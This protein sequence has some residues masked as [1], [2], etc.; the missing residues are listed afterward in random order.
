MALIERLMGLEQ[1]KISVHLFQSLAAEWAQGS[2]TGTQANA[3]IAA[4]SGGVPLDAAAIA[5]ATALVATVPTG[6][7]SALKADRAL[8]LLDIDHVLLIAESRIPPYDTAAAVRTRLG[9]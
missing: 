5:E 1:P 4:Q 3:A 6:T 2:I 7:T 9:I 8:K